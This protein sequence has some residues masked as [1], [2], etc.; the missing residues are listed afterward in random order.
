MFPPVCCPV[1]CCQLFVAG[2]ELTLALC[3]IL[4]SLPRFSACFSIARFFRVRSAVCDSILVVRGGRRL[5][6]IFGEPSLGGNFAGDGEMTFGDPEVLV[7]SAMRGRRRLRCDRLRRYKVSSLDLWYRLCGVQDDDAAHLR[8]GAFGGFDF[9]HGVAISGEVFLIVTCRVVAHIESEEF[10]LPWSFSCFV[11]GATGR[12][13]M[14]LFSIGM[15]R[16]RLIECVA[17]VFSLFFE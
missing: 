6:I 1:V 16:K 8:D 14:A 2:C 12:R 11:A 7:C 4:Y 5:T 17:L 10:F 15:S 3:L 13:R 9:V